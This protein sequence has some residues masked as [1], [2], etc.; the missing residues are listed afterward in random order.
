VHAKVLC[1]AAGLPVGPWVALAPGVPVPASLDLELPVFVKPARAGSSLGITRVTRWPDLAA[2]VT[3]ARRHDPKV[4]VEQ[5]VTGREVECG[6]LGRHEGRARASVPAEIRI[7]GDHAFYDFEAKYLDGATELLCPAD[8]PSAVVREVQELAVRAF[9]AL[10]CAGL[11]RVDF[12]LS[13]SGSLVLNEVN[14]MP[15]FTP[16]S[17]FPRM[18]SASGLD[19]AALVDHV[20]QLALRGGAGLR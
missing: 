4:I 8:L 15:G 1:A 2:A 20:V 11:A 3:E 18:W 9:E 13:S 10:D 19:H 17:M 5:G 12:F 7:V 6:V 14:T 16:V